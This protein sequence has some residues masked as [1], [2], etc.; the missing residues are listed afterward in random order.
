M[1]DLADLAERVREIVE[2]CREIERRSETSLAALTRAMP[3]VDF[4][5]PVYLV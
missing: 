1:G 4:Y 2:R 3:G 5:G